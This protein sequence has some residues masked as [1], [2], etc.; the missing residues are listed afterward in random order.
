MVASERLLLITAIQSSL[1]AV[2][3]SHGPGKVSP[4]FQGQAHIVAHVQE[5]EVMRPLKCVMLV[6]LYL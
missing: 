3:E 6:Y 4:P 1:E 5:T 2:T